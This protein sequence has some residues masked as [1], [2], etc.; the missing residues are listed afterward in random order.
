ME[1]KA[2]DSEVRSGVSGP[3]AV[4]GGTSELRVIGP[5]GIVYAPSPPASWGRES[6]LAWRYALLI[7]SSLAEPVPVEL[8]MSHYALEIPLVA[9]RALDTSFGIA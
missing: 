8:D 7:A 2:V 9:F 1:L 3:V 5:T 6:A 4:E